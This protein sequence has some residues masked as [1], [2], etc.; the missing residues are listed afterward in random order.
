MRPK[1]THC[2]R[3]HEYTPQTSVW[4]TGNNGKPQRACRTCRNMRLRLKYHSDA[5]FRQTTLA[6]VAVY[7]QEI[8]I[9]IAQS[10]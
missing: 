9:L 5:A 10:Q 6:R 4:S 1:P 3:G 7:K 2:L 8:K